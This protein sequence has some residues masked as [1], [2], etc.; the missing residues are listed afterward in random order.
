MCRAG[1]REGNRKK[2]INYLRRPNKN[3]RKCR[4]LYS[5]G[6]MGDGNVLMARDGMKRLERRSVFLILCQQRL[7]IPPHYHLH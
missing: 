7:P 4:I 3:E 1:D 5:S 2:E 6:K